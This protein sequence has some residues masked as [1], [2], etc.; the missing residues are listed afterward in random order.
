MPE[1]VKPWVIRVC[2]H[3]C[4]LV[5]LHGS[6]QTVHANTSP[7]EACDAPLET[8]RAVMVEDAAALEEAR[9]RILALERACAWIANP[10]EWGTEDRPEVVAQ[11]VLDSG[12]EQQDRC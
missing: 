5:Y 11:A 2:E 8:Q 3:G 1:R 10:D 4:Q 9:E 7:V 12:A 6:D